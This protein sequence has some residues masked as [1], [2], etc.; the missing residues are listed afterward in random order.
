MLPGDYVAV[1]DLGLNLFIEHDPVFIVSGSESLPSLYQNM[2][3]VA[4]R[5]GFSDV[6]LKPCRLKSQVVAGAQ[7]S[8]QNEQLVPRC[9]FFGVASTSQATSSLSDFLI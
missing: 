6:Q 1:L 4:Y 8:G 9:D 2:S 7:N 5:F 3:I